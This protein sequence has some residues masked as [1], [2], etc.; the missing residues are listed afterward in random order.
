MHCTELA[1]LVTETE[2]YYKGAGRAIDSLE[3][4][5]LN[6]GYFDF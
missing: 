2:P 3:A 4:S 6:F 1:Q 5:D